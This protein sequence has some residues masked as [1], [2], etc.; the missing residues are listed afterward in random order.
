MGVV[1]YSSS[2]IV[3]AA[4][5]D[6]FDEIQKLLKKLFYPIQYKNK[7][8]GIIIAR[9]E[10]KWLAPAGELMVFDLKELATDNK[11]E[12][13]IFSKDLLDS[14]VNFNRNVKNVNRLMK[15]LKNTLS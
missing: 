10:Q 7:E 8:K 12:V 4:I 3:S 15:E 14:G 6:T 1:K 11:V 9:V 13:L 2:I 5:N